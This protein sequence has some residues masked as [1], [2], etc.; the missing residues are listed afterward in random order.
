MRPVEPGWDVFLMGERERRAELGLERSLRPLER[1]GA[2]VVTEDGRRLLSFSSNDYL[3]LAF[4]PAVIDAAARAARRGAGATASRLIVG[5]DRAYAELEAKLADF[6][7]CESALV[8]G[9]GYLAN[10][11]VIA[12]LL[13]RDDAVFSDRLNHASIVDGIRLSR[14]ALYRFGHLDLDELEAMLQQAERAGV[15]RKL[16]VT[17]S[18]FSMDGD[19]APLAEIVELKERYGAALLV[20][21]AHAEGV[22]GPQGEGYAHELGLAD[23]I[24]LHLGTFSKAFGSYGAYVAGGS[25]WVQHLVNAARSL[26]FTTGLPPAVIAAVDAAIELVRDAGDTRG[27]L[28]ATAERFRVGLHEL[29]LPTG[30]SSTQIVP[31]VVGESEHAL[32]LSRALEQ[33]GVLAIAIRPPTVP[34]GSARLRF[35]LTALHGDDELDTALAAVAT[36]A[37]GRAVVD[38]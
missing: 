27:R 35:S 23:R 36:A 20:D 14:A 4:R 28:Q 8:F 17:E 38:A 29:G 7:G 34:A 11:G 12:G 3:G 2:W 26:I 32:D 33:E 22:F 21:E 10:A 24:D 15:R 25:L 5:S 6:Q 16:I 9:S 13:G 19:V 37:A 31:V 30:G 18:V 1:D